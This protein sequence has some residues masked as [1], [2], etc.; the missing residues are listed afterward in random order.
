MR[1]VIA[2]SAEK[3]GFVAGLKW[4]PLAG[5]LGNK[6]TSDVRSKA[7]LV[8]AERI[9]L[10]SA[11]TGDAIQTALGMYAPN[12][13]DKTTTATTLHS[14]AAA[15]VYAYP[16]HLHLILAWRL[17]EKKVAVIVVQ[18]GVPIADEIK[19]ELEAVQLMK[20]ALSGKMGQSG[21]AIYTNDPKAFLGGTMATAEAFFK[22][23]SKS[24]RL[25]GIPVRKSYIVGALS[26]LTLIAAGSAFAYQNHIKTE[27]AKLAAQIAAEDP[28][29]AYQAL[30]AVNI[31]RLG[32]DRGALLNVIAG[33]NDV[34]VWEG[35]WLLSQIECSVDQCVY[36]WQRDGGTTADLRAAN[37]GAEVMAGSKSETVMLRRAVKLPLS[38]LRSLQDAVSQTAV[39]N[40]YVNTYQLWR[41]AKLAV[42]ETEDLNEFKIWP[43][44]VGGGADR[45]PKSMTLKARKIVVTLPLPLAQEVV[46]STPSAVWWSSLVLKYSPSDAQKLLT[47]TLTGNTYVQ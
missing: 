5:Y 38:G 16:E 31:G 41:N 18:N 33:F 25:I 26:A 15:C 45:L 42:E 8:M 6:V 19:D 28:L 34:K 11:N 46:L 7:G 40:D 39:T 12:E 21:H 14:L 22:A 47:V 9:I 10:H 37:P 44:P 20:T 30:L 2:F 1:T 43:A 23:A 17:D 36:T 35:G 24:T 4:V 29:P 3:V 32:F 27:R 13:F